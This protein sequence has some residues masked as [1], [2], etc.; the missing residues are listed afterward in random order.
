MPCSRPK[1]G[2]A[3]EESGGDLV[4]PLL[5]PRAR[6]ASNG[7]RGVHDYDQEKGAKVCVC[8]CV[9]ACMCAPDV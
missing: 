4:T 1:S 2:A 5:E 9:Y 6:E 8:E 7:L 3:A